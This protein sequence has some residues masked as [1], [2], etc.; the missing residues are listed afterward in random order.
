MLV[1][2]Y[3]KKIEAMVNDSDSGFLLIDKPV[4]EPSMHTVRQLRR[5][6]GQRTIGF[7]GTLDPAASGLL[8]IGIN[9][10][11]KLLD[12]WHR[13]PKEYE[14]EITLGKMSTTYDAEGV[15]TEVKN[16]KFKV[17][18]DAIE[19]AARQLIG[20]IQQVPPMYSAKS[21]GG[22]RLYEL[23]RAGQEVKRQAATVIIYSM[24]ILDYQY[25][26]VKIKVRCSSGTYIRSLAHDLGQAL[27][28]G[29]YLSGLRRMAIGPFNV[30][31]VIAVADLRPDSWR[32]QFLDT[33]IWKKFLHR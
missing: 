20:S 15:I 30:A 27:G 10:A 29:A 5:T 33:E 21:I 25:P 19:N 17:E 23:A 18:R 3:E 31:Q 16:L 28:A 4:G 13:W 9:K 14:A 24:D 7:A 6:T 22:K 26:I 2:G 12:L 11:T 8:V 1:T 32:G